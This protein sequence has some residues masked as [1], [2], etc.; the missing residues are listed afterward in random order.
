MRFPKYSVG[1]RVV[2]NGNINDPIE[3]P[4]EILDIRLG[5]SGVPEYLKMSGSHGYWLREEQLILV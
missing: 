4:S 3:R 1:N 5:G 2:F